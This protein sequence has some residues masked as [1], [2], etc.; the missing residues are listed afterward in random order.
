[1]AE[2]GWSPYPY[3]LESAKAVRHDIEG[4]SLAR[5]ELCPAAL[6]QRGLVDVDVLAAAIVGDVATERRLLRR[7]ALHLACG[8]TRRNSPRR[9]LVHD[10]LV[11]EHLNA[12]FRLEGFPDLQGHLDRAALARI[13]VEG[14]V[15]PG[16]RRAAGRFECGGRVPPPSRPSRRAS[17]GAR[18]L[19]YHAP[20]RSRPAGACAR[21][22]P[23][24]A[25]ASACCA[26]RLGREGGRGTRSPCLS[27]PSP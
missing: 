11:G 1:M 19:H 15:R 3:R 25:A 20:P 13:D 4:D 7:V 14:G 8:A 16:L 12:G 9:G 5:R 17:C 24:C 21:P 27:G 10:G 26:L 22:L 23:P 6:A 18:D 2:S